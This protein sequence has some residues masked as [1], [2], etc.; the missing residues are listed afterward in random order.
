MTL[1]HSKYLFTV[2]A[3]TIAFGFLFSGIPYIGGPSLALGHLYAVFS[4]VFLPFMLLQKMPHKYINL[5]MFTVGIGSSFLYFMD[6]HPILIITLTSMLAWFGDK[7]EGPSVRERTKSTVLLIF[8]YIFGFS[9]SMVSN[10]LIKALYLGTTVFD[11]FLNQ[12][13]LYSPD[14]L[15]YLKTVVSLIFLSFILSQ[16]IHYKYINSFIFMLG[17]LPSSLYFG[18]DHPTL[19]IVLTA[20]LVFF[21]DKREGVSFREK[22][23][24]IVLLI[25]LYIFGFLISMILES[26]IMTL[27]FGTGILNE[28]SDVLRR[29]KR[30]FSIISLYDL[31]LF[32]KRTGM[33]DIKLLFS[34]IATSSL[35]A[36]FVS[37]FLAIRLYCL[38]KNFSG[39]HGIIIFSILILVSV[40][41]HIIFSQHSS[42]H[43]HFI[44]RWMFLPYSLCYGCF[45]YSLIQWR[46]SCKIETGDRKQDE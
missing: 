7:R 45:V 21:G 6:G 20:A 43:Q 14:L 26:I 1:F 19:I 2:T 15:G 41:R 38:R 29:K 32:W 31:S 35:L 25:F 3:P 10:Q 5:F 16:K 13:W 44:G 28:F 22:V 12:L 18:D 40:Y 27:G 46:S 42:T 37:T 11:Q 24:S 34:A 36:F 4:L 23:K 30:K 33:L 9:I 17:I 39:I 8:L